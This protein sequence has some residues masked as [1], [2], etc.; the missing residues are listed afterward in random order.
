[1]YPIKSNSRRKNN[2]KNFWNVSAVINFVFFCSF[3]YIFSWLFSGILIF[4]YRL[5]CDGGYVTIW[6]LFWMWMVLLTTWFPISKHPLCMHSTRAFVK[7][8][9][10]FHCHANLFRAEWSSIFTHKDNEAYVNAKKKASMKCMFIIIRTDQ[11][12]RHDNTVMMKK[13]IKE[14]ELRWL[15]SWL[16]GLTR[17]ENNIDITT[18]KLI[19]SLLNFLYSVNCLAGLS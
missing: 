8:A 9:T 3:F 11:V 19:K 13:C 5:L 14:H 1:M 7:Q 15:I 16:R 4:F 12:G 2:E 10:V 17:C 18:R 6:A